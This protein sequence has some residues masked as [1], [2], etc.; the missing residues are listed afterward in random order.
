MS[1]LQI[2]VDG[3]GLFGPGM[4]GWA[5]ARAVLSAQQ[6]L[7]PGAPELP[8]AT[9][10]PPA[11]RRRVGTA[12]KLAM[13]SGFEAVQHAGADAAQLATVFSSTG[14]DCDNCHAILETLA[15]DDRAVSPTRFHNSVHNAPAGYWSIATGCMASSTSLC[16]FDATFAAGLL[17]AAVQALSSG[18]PCL[19]IAFD[20]AYPQP[21]QALRP[22]PYAMG[23]GLLL[24]PQ[25]TAAARATLAITLSQDAATVMPDPALEALRLRIPAARSLPLMQHLARGS[26]GTVVID[27]LDTPNLSIEVRP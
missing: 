2:H 23:V 15:S 14:G 13:A 25:R 16:A 3:I 9:A 17:D 12:I 20:T 19:L 11:E 8:P 1:P 6:P 26:H 24:N 4:S 21:L 18:Q 5:Q 22:I 10:L 7:L 27:Y